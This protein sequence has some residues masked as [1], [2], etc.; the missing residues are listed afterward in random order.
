[1]GP[2]GAATLRIVFAAV[3][4]MA[5]TRPW[6][7]WPAKAPLW[8]LAGLGLSTAGAMVMFY[9]AIERLPQGVAIALQFLGPLSIALLGSRRARDLVWALLAGAGVWALVGQGMGRAPLDPA[10]VGW[11]L[12]AACA[13]AGYIIC[14][15]AA[16]AAFGKSA[17]A[18]ATTVAAV[19]ILP[20]G[21]VHAGGGLLDLRL[22]PLALAVAL[23]STAIPFSL[24]LY[25]MPRLP[26]RTFS[27]FASLEPAL[28]ALSGFVLLHEALS[29]AQ[30]V[31][32]AAVIAAAA[33]AAWST[34]AEPE[35]ELN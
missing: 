35:L 5:A 17:A 12:G 25:A 27:V 8:P 4:L 24:E 15:R 33:G 31:G 3:M 28:G 16:G 22:I 7:S 19:L 11:A 32:L 26:A 30:L 20:V 21:I 1:V 6:R 13:W 2:Q 18:L 29:P 10:G 23:F 14:G 34:T 9:L